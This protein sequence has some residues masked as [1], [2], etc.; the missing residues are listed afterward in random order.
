MPKSVIVWQEPKE[1]TLLSGANTLGAEGIV[2]LE[3]RYKF[4]TVQVSG[5]F[6]ATVSFE[7][8]VD[9]TNWAAVQGKNLASGSAASSATAA[10]IFVFEVP[11][12]AKFRARVS[13]YTSGS[14]SAVAV[15][16]PC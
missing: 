5:T 1:L 4:L 15:A 16:V 12:L 14:V 13:A 6:T 2:E 11:G 10:G 3:G 9:G 8:T 7:G